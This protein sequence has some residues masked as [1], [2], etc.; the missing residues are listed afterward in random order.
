MLV[1]PVLVRPVLVRSNEDKAC[2][3]RKGVT[4]SHLRNPSSHDQFHWQTPLASSADQFRWPVP[5]TSSAGKFRWQAGKFRWHSADRFHWPTPRHPGF[6]GIHFG[7]KSDRL[8]NSAGKFRWQVPLASS[9]GKFCWHSAGTPL[10]S[11]SGTLLTSSL[12]SSAK[13]EESLSALAGASPAE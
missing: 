1:R 11:S 2:K 4:F 5:L 3:P 6:E 9:A 8:S 13:R 12:T 10:T 7:K